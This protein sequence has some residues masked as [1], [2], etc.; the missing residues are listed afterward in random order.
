[1][2]NALQ[3]GKKI[4]GMACILVFGCLLSVLSCSHAQ[5]GAGDQD[6][7]Q[8]PGRI[9]RVAYPELEGM[10]ETDENGTRHGI[11]VDYLNEI[12]KYTGWQY[13]Y[14]DTAAEDMIPEFLDGQYD[15]MGGTYYQPEFEQYFAYP[16]YNTGYN[17]SVLLVRR[18]DKS[19]KTYDWKSMSGKTIGVYERAEENI[20]RLQAF[21]DLNGIDCTIRYFSKDQLVDGNLYQ[22]LEDREVDMLLGNNADVKGNL[23]VVA[24]FD[25]QPYYIVTTPDNQEVLDGMNMALGKIVDSNPNF[26]E[27]RYN[28]NFP[29]SGIESICL[30]DEEQ[31][32]IREKQKVSVAVVKEWHPLF[33]QEEDTDMHN[34][35]IP[36]VLEKV[37]EFS[38]LEFSY[39]YTDTYG[40]ALNLVNQGKAD[41]LGAFLGSEEDGADMGLA[42]SKAYASMSD[43]IVRNKGVSYPSD[44]LVGAVIEGR[45]MPTGIKADEIRYFPDVRAALRAVN[46]GEVDFFYGISTKIE[47]DMQAHHYPNVVPNTLVNNRNDICFAVTR[48]VDGE[49]LPILNKSVNSLSSEQKTALTNQNMITIGSRSASIVEL[50]YA[51]PFMFLTLT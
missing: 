30:N 32:Y 17:K 28:A 48:P 7:A 33:S 45:R 10:S 25:S 23:R 21:L 12:A 1:M 29:D 2:K 42:L 13:E 9:L 37:T 35:L 24:E 3:A 15:L 31:A 46:N 47:H 49:L 11:V 44:G 34:G 6:K 22:C 8:G 14:I 4:A 19:I 40:D 43:I 38:G 39:E 41:I 5:A 51:I 16:D 27:E 18:D 36:D 50:M 20:R 26:A